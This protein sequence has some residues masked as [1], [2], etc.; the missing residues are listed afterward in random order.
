L[1]N[2][3]RFGIYS[4]TKN[5]N[6]YLIFMTGCLRNGPFYAYNALNLSTIFIIILKRFFFSLFIYL[7]VWEITVFMHIRYYHGHSFMLEQNVFSQFLLIHSLFYW[8]FFFLILKVQFLFFDFLSNVILWLQILYTLISTLN[9]IQTK[10]D[11]ISNN[12]LSI[13]TK[14][15]KSILGS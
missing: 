2:W 11:R 12:Y 7:F 13:W 5:W 8:F 10:F 1:I 6:F 4:F 14:V 15:V 9:T 3:V